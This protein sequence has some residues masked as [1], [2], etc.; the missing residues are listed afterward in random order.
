MT[1][2]EKRFLDEL[3]IGLWVGAAPNGEVIYTNAAF[4]EILGMQ[5]VAESRVE[6]IP[7]TYRVFDRDGRP[8]PVDRLAISRVLATGEAVVVDDMVIHRDDGRRV[9]LRTFGQPVRDRAGRITH[10]LMAFI[11]ITREM[12]AELGRASVEA[13]LKMAVDHAPIA[14][15]SIDRNGTITLSAG[16]GLEA[17]GVRSGD[18]V[19]KSVFE[20]YRDHPTIPDYIRR[21]L[22]GGSFYYTVQVGQAI[23]D[24][25]IMPIR[26]ASGQVIGVLGVSHDMSEPRRLQAAVIQND[27]VRAMGMLAASV[28]HEINNP[29]TYVMGS[30]EN[31]AHTLDQQEAR[32]ADLNDLPAAVDLREAAAAMRR[33]LELAGA[34]TERIATITRD[35]RSYCRP[36]DS[37]FEPID[38]RAAIES[39]LRLLRKDIQARARLVLALADTAPVFASEARLVQVVTNLLVNA[40]QALPA[41]PAAAQEISIVTRQEG[42]WVVI[43]VSDSGSGVAVAERERVFEPF[44]TTKSVGEGTGLGLF[45][46]RNIINGLGGKITLGDRPGGGALFRVELPVAAAVAGG[47]QQPTSARPGSTS[48]WRVLVIDDDPRV[49]E[50]LAAQ[51]KRAGMRVQV[52]TDGQA[53]PAVLLADSGFDLIYCD[54][55][56]AGTT[57]MD[58][59]DLLQARAPDRL[60]RTVFMTGGAF[61]PRAA[62]FVSAHSDCCVEK[63]FDVVAETRR[64]LASIPRMGVS[65]SQ[66]GARGPAGR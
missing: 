25:W 14:I 53:A 31:L 16:A 59:A 1:D 20:L 64:R 27:R 30:L 13:Q 63:P 38:V 2:L 56:M 41:G 49:A 33:D 61:T 55:M 43:E 46:C 10:V 51:L 54:L 50:M 6:D 66:P 57:G 42:Q 45:V 65:E 9:P 37:H 48:A 3:P 23:Y 17:L 22:E 32:L 8:Y 36:A 47:H 29:L 5:P 19:G 21:G 28:A 11:D 34:G 39:V 62:A 60:A 35:L 15:F 18:L 52:I 26:D 58:L 4:R 7:S 40:Q 44:M 24:S 12:D